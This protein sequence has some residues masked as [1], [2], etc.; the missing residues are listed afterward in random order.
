M[1][2]VGNFRLCTLCVSFKD[3]KQLR[4][5]KLPSLNTVLDI[6]Q[7]VQD[8]SNYQTL[9]LLILIEEGL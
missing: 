7:K 1:A 5:I 2:R 3:K 4:D 9:N 6:D 8:N